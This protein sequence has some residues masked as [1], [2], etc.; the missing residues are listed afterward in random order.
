[1]RA[2]KIVKHDGMVG[3]VIITPIRKTKTHHHWGVQYHEGKLGCKHTW[4]KYPSCG[5]P[6][7]VGCDNI[8]Q[9]LDLAEEY[10]ALDDNGE[11]LRGL[12]Q[13]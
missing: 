13:I 8:T 4:F 9:A 2:M 7:F 1:M 5:G 6:T 3:V 11:F 10:F 12:G